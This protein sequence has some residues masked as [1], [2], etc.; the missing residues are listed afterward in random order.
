M[1]PSLPPWLHRV[2]EAFAR[3]DADGRLAHAVLLDAP[4]GW[5][6]L[7]LAERFA[8]TILEREVDFELDCLLDLMQIDIREKARAI[9]INQVRN[10][11]E[12]LGSTSRE[13]PR[14]L[15]LIK[16]ADKL[17][18]PASQALLK[19]LEEPPGDKH[20]LLVTAN[21]AHLPPTIRSR[22]Q[23]F[24][25]Q[26]GTK[27]EVAAYF[28]SRRV[29]SPML[30]DFLSDYGGAPFS[31]LT[32]LEEKRI[33]LKQKL[34]DVVRDQ[35]AVVPTARELRGDEVD[36]VLLRWQH[37]TLGL[38]HNSERVGPVAKFYDELSDVR[39]QFR[40]VPGLDSERQYIRLL[41]KWRSL[42]K[43]HQRLPR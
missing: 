20:L 39:R 5:G 34:R 23:R 7:A 3:S 25:V 40:E 26:A 41:I 16:R 13:G 32:A 22:C 30:D 38:A 31:T 19:V 37:V 12:F 6:V 18:I 27:E 29:D 9:A 15:V 24:L 42:L 14:K 28:Q 10:A 36:D 17:S 21:S 33:N 43:Q 11:A 4:P 2:H 8:E 1:K 35:A